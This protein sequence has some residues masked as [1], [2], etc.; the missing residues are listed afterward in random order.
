MQALK[1]DCHLCHYTIYHTD[2]PFRSVQI[3]EE[4][5]VIWSLKQKPTWDTDMNSNNFPSLISSSLHGLQ[6]RSEINEPWSLL[7]SADI[8]H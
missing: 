1:F 5:S 2:Q 4:N 3:F 6:Y 7:F 8:I